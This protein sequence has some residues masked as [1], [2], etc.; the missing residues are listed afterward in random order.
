M[1]NQERARAVFVGYFSNRAFWARFRERFWAK[2][3]L[4]WA[5]YGKGEISING[6]SLTLRGRRLRPFR[7]STKHQVSI[8]LRDIFNIV[9][10]GC[11]IHCY[12]QIPYTRDRPLRMWLQDDWSAQRLVQLIHTRRA[13][14]TLGA[15][16]PNQPE[17]FT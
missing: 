5:L 2:P 17:F 3:Q 9:R 10:D 16:P 6:T 13:A 7:T 12:V 11:Y 8:P 15:P 4:G 14:A 1:V